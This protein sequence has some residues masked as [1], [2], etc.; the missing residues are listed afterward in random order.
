MA[1]VIIGL[2]AGVLVCVSVEFVDRVLRVDDPVGAISVHGANGLWGVISVGLFADGKSNYGGAWNGVP[3]S[4]TGLF[5]GDAGQLVAQLMGV[6]TLVGFVFT[7]SF[8]LNLVID[9][10]MG[11]RVSAKVELEGLDIPE[12]GA[13]RLSGLRAQGRRHGDGVT[14]HVSRTRQ[15]A[16][17]AA[18]AAARRSRRFHGGTRIRSRRRHWRST[19]RRSRQ[20]CLENPRSADLR[21]C[22][23][24]AYAVNYDVYK[25]MDALEAAVGVDPTHFWA[26]LKYG[27]LQYRL[28]ALA[29][30]EEETV[31]GARSGARTAGSWPLARKQLQEIRRLNRESTRNVTLGQATDSAGADARRA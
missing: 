29:R 27:E 14:D 25:S 5:Y 18:A 23:G 3:G 31:E 16:G 15:N 4:V 28:R 22:L 12:M 13:R 9:A 21:T 8:V 30:A 20:A 24:M 17:S 26:Q 7:L 10:A 11:Q 1:S 6:A 2:I 19:S